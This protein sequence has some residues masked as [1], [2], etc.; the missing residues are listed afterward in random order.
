M[1]QDDPFRSALLTYLDELKSRVSTE[2]GDWTV[3]GFI[4]IYKRVYTVSIDTKV[5]SKVLEL[6]MFPVLVRFA[7][8]QDYRIVLARAQNHY[9]DLSLISSDDSLCI[10]ID[11]KSTYRTLPDRQG[12]QRVSGM[13]LGTF[14]GY[15]R[16]RDR[17]VSSTFPYNRYQKH[18]V[19]GVV[20]SR[21]EGIDEREVYDISELQRIPSVVN[22][23]E[24]FFQ[25]K[26]RI[27]SDGPGSGNTKNI[28]STKY[29]DRLINGTGVFANLGIEVFD[30]YWMNYQTRE[31]ARAEGFEKPPYSNLK[32]YREHKEQ[33]A[34]I[35]S[36]PVD[37]LASEVEEESAVAPDITAT[38]SVSLDDES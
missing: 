36:I 28:G 5:L 15:F 3:K 25:E 20:Y 38:D 17:I 2:S 9:P 19:L 29:L 12:R 31:M 18:Y 6:L 32:E 30:D 16:L 14:G 26:Y 37:Q 4:D 13:T 34:T 24:F 11:I 22:N 1:T 33:G 27:A 35:L 8:E 7:K 23:F 21:V 10:A